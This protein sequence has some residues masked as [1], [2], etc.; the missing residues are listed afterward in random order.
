MK[1]NQNNILNE[2]ATFNM[3]ENIINN[4]ALRKVRF[5]VLDTPNKKESAKIK[6]PNSV[7]SLNKK[8]LSKLKTKLSMKSSHSKTNKKSIKKEKSLFNVSN[9]WSKNKLRKLS[10]SNFDL[11]NAPISN[12]SKTIKNNLET[13]SFK[14]DA[15]ITKTQSRSDSN[16]KINN[17]RKSNLEQTKNNF[18]KLI[19]KTNRGSYVKDYSNRN[20]NYSLVYNKQFFEVYEGDSLKNVEKKLQN[21]I[22]DME[23]EA[24][25]MQFEIG[26]LDISINRFN[27]KKKKQKISNKTTK[28]FE[29]KEKEQNE[30]SNLN[31]LNSE[32]YLMNKSNR[33]F[34]ESDNKLIL[35]EKNKVNSN[36]NL[37]DKFKLSSTNYKNTKYKSDKETNITSN[38]YKKNKKKYSSRNSKVSLYEKLKSLFKTNEP[39]FDISQKDTILSKNKFNSNIDSKF[40]TTIRENTESFFKANS[41]ISEKEIGIMDKGKFR[42]LM[43]KKLLYDSLDDEELIEDAVIENFYLEPNSTFVIIVDTMVLI[44]T[45]WSI[46]Y[47]PLYLVLNNCDIQNTMTSITFN[48]ISNLFIDALFIC[49]LI[50]NCFKAYYNFDEQL[51]TKTNR[52]FVHYLKKFFIV[53]FISAI[54]YY[55]IIKFI[56]LKRF[57]NYGIDP[58]CS[59]YYDHKIKDWFQLVEL[60]KLIKVF[61]CLSRNNI[62]TNYILRQLNEFIFFENWSFLLSTMCLFFLSLH[63]TAC[64]HI[65]ISITAYPNWIILN[66]FNFS[67]FP[68]IY[69][70]SVYFL[71]AT[72]TS[73]GYGDII[74]NSF[75]EFCFQIIILLVGIIAYSWLI[76]SISNYIK[77]KNKANE[78][79]N[80]KINILNGI[81]LE[82]PNIPQELYDKIYLHLEYIN[83]KQ[84]KDK[85]ALI[86]SLPHT[87][88]KSLLYEMYK[89]II[90]N[91]NFFKNFKNSEFINQVISKVK[92]IIAVKNDLLLDQ[93]EIIEETFFVKQ[94]RLS[95][96]VKIDINHPEKSVQKLLDKEYFFGVENNELYHKNAFALMDMSTIEKMP[97]PNSINQK[98]LYNLYSRSSLNMS[99]VN[100][101]DI[102]SIIT[103]EQGNE[104]IQKHQN[105]N[106]NYIYLKI[107]DI[108]KNEHFGALLMFLN[109]RSPLSLR[110]KTKK[111]ELYLLKKLDAIEI[112]SSYPNIWK[113]VNRASF[114][115]LKQIKK[116]MNKIIKHF[117]ETYGI[118]FMKKICQENS[119]KDINDLKKLYTLQ[120]KISKDY[121]N[122]NFSIL[123]GNNHQNPKRFS[124]FVTKSQLKMLKEFINNSDAS[125]LKP[126]EEN[127][128][129]QPNIKDFDVENNLNIEKDKNLSM[130]KKIVSSFGDDSQM[131]CTLNVIK[132]KNNDNPS[133]QGKTLSGLDD[134][135]NTIEKI[136]N[137][138]TFSEES[139]NK[140]QN[141]KTK[142]EVTNDKNKYG[143][144]SAKKLIENYGTPFNPEDIND[145]IYSQEIESK[146]SDDN[147]NEKVNELEFTPINYLLSSQ[148]SIKNS[149]KRPKTEFFKKKINNSKSHEINNVIINNSFITKHVINNIHSMKIKNQLSTFHFGFNFKSKNNESN[150]KPNKSNEANKIYNLAIFQNSFELSAFKNQEKIDLDLNKILKDKNEDKK[151]IIYENNRKNNKNK[152][153]CSS[154]YSCSSC[155]SCKRCSSCLEEK[156]KEKKKSFTYEIPINKVIHSS[157]SS[158][159]TVKQN[160]VINKELKIFKNNELKYNSNYFNLNQMTNGKIINNINFRNYLKNI[161]L[162]KI[163]D[164]TH[165]RME[166][167]KIRNHLKSFNSNKM[168]PIPRK[169]ISKKYSALL[170][171]HNL[172]TDKIKE[173]IP[174][175]KK[176]HSIIPTEMNPRDKGNYY[177][178]KKIFRKNNNHPNLLNYI[179]KNIKDDSVVLHDPE[180]FYSGLFNNIMEKY[181]KANI[182]IF[183][184]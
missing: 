174:I 168:L 182:N 167:P 93:G 3:K 96:E 56:A 139:K 130:S 160:E 35:N 43:H 75:I 11:N 166:F 147:N 140:S 116:I 128:I 64:T 154:S 27:L 131:N 133:K 144:E 134:K 71:L 106:S 169:E 162:E 81:K 152:S 57:L 129:E 150:Y 117:C 77:E 12:S 103:N 47:K 44:C 73:V 85:S 91:F 61:K 119:I 176:S 100:K 14:T 177:S 69:L 17:R 60:L 164:L 135:N 63:L 127:H 120:S 15:Q 51:I 87:I 1:A 78:L 99:N 82:H 122:N 132:I 141:T 89:P 55:S 62:V 180:K 112:S 178:T 28:D 9:N 114:H 153:F 8:D 102:K 146:S 48:N 29:K 50:I 123:Q 165:S 84:K 6:T 4:N 151:N 118:N 173:T 45:F 159:S 25:I 137:K 38:T 86:D 183:Q 92:P 94:G 109:K 31:N 33:N 175:N 7:R 161:I 40:G 136:N 179:N 67:S 16:K 46:V 88:T 2:N 74:G 79:F 108:R 142:D 157:S 98:N 170:P 181:S 54:P 42:I 24:D 97:T 53:D 39:K 95:L 171:F 65:F 80:R 5:N 121:Y 126:Y 18:L 34:D 22:I 58:K 156:Y 115:N 66:N 113:R 143:K 49:D 41:L 155:S 70:A 21:K 163:P 36:R 125:I 184:K 104:E 32:K 26:P 145:E 158:Y 19:T 23:K 59:E 148:E 83:L 149:Y 101:K 172:H 124:A 105:T 138:N 37:T 76:S 107:L 111:A 13:K 20:S 10:K 110:V 68:T 90:E 72:V 30:S 52:I